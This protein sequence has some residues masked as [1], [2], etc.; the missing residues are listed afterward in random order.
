MSPADRS[1][2]RT[3][4]H[5]MCCSSDLRPISSSVCCPLDN[6]SV[7]YPCVQIDNTPSYIPS[8]AAPDH[9]DPPIPTERTSSYPGLTAAVPGSITSTSRSQPLVDRHHSTPSATENLYP[10]SSSTRRRRRRRTSTPDPIRPPTELTGD[11]AGDPPATEAGFLDPRTISTH[12]RPEGGSPSPKRRRLANMR[13]DGV[14]STNGLS[15]ASNGSL[16]S[17]SHKAGFSHSLNGRTPYT[18]SNG[19]F[20]PNGSQKT[21]TSSSYFGHDREEVTRILIQS[22]FELGYNGA[23]TLL[24]KE[25]GYQLESPAVATFRNAVLEGRWAEAERILVHSFYPDGGG[26]ALSSGDPSS[27]KERLVLVDNAGL[28]EMLFHLRQQKFLELLEARDLGAALMVLRHELTPLNYDISRLHALSSLLMCPP[29]HL[30]DQAGWDGSIRS[31]RE[32]LLS[33][34]SRFISPSVMIPD[35]RLAILL[36]H[37]KQNQIN[38][39]LYHNTATPP[40]LYSDHLCDRS[41][42]P[43]RTKIELSHHGDEVWYCQFSHDGTKLA[44]A[45]KDRL[46]NIHDTNTFAVLHKLFEHDDGVA[47]VSWSPDDTK[48]ITCSQDN[49]ARVW[50]VETGRCL[51]TINHHQHPV[52]AAA[53]APD[54]ESFV[55]TSL[56]LNKQMCHWSMRGQRLY[57]WPAGFR[58]QDCA[59]TP[60][61]RRLIAADVEEKIHVYNF[62]THEEEY[63]LA[64]KSKP[65]SLAVSKDS[66]H[67]L[68]N[69][70]EGQIQLIDIDTTDVVRR[71]QGQ[72]QGSYIIRS[73]FGGAAENFVVSGSEDSRV[74]IWHK[75]NGTLVETLEGHISGCVNSICWNP[76]NPGMFASAGDDHMIRIWAR[77]RDLHPGG[78]IVDEHLTISPGSFGRTSALRSTSGT[79]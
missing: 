76:T 21:S 35:N 41:D 73:A 11:L 53:W 16:A 47:H 22:L 64:L 49:K 67:M 72:K 42:F 56:D 34:L 63:C 57:V 10:P 39:C 3:G 7:G 23:A 26:R 14:S 9:P 18:P 28:N 15:Q 32:R 31:S 66:R 17:P 58:V 79:H 19:E 46:V 27:A 25:S 45:G 50:S 51:L 8:S 65:T 69:L 62:L 74:Y 48:L 68:V 4:R 75:E 2:G 5:M 29:E 71:F 60:D 54:G 20:H 12:A 44:T 37:V 1:D 52:T 59:I 38:Q 55:T 40:S 61:G 70:S 6:R 24:S 77:E 13:P 43:L 36:D 33:A 78:T 30:H